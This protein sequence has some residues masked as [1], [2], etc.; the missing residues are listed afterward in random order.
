[1]SGLLS[2]FVVILAVTIGM[3]ITFFAVCVVC[4]DFLVPSIDVF[5]DQFKIPEDVAGVTL[6]AFGS[7]APELFL[8]L[9]TLLMVQVIYHIAPL[10]E[11]NSSVWLIPPL[12]ILMTKEKELE[13]KTWPIVREIVFYL[14]GL[15]VS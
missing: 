1:M 13:L 6:V 5:I 7:A 2:L 12:C 9:M 15:I 10:G 8:N 14:I 11:L 3:G 4:D